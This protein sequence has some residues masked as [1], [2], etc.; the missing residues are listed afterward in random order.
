MNKLQKLCL[1][2]L[3]E[4]ESLIYQKYNLKINPSLVFDLKTTSYYGYYD[5]ETNEIHLHLPLLKEFKKLYINEVLTHEY[6]HAV[7]F[8]LYGYNVKP[9]GKEWKNIMK[10][11]GIKKPAATTT[12]F[13]NSEFIR[14]NSY[15]YKCNCDI[16]Y[17][18]KYIHNRIQKGYKYYCKRCNGKL[19]EIQK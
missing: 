13:D 18:S 17:L 6:A 5:E 4:L 3:E 2:K 7:V 12:I 16:Y 8:K 9:H 1:S 11:L 19:I 14:K 15:L 10:Y